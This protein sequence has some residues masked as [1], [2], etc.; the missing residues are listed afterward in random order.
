[1]TRIR[2][3]VIVIAVLATVVAALMIV[4][5]GAE[6]LTAWASRHEHRQFDE[7]IATLSESR[8]RS[9]PSGAGVSSSLNSARSGSCAES[10]RSVPPASGCV[11]KP[12]TGV[13]SSR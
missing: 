12:A 6:R 5:D 7:I 1:M 2:R 13:N 8:S 11:M 9:S 4:L 3:D 10:Y